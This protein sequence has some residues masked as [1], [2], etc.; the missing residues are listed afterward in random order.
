MLS[1]GNSAFWQIKFRC[2]KNFYFSIV[3]KLLVFLV[4]F[5]SK[6]N[7]TNTLKGCYLGVSILEAFWGRFEA[8]SSKTEV[9]KP[10]SFK[11]WVRIQIQLPL[12][13]P[14]EK[15]QKKIFGC[16]S[17]QKSKIGYTNKRVCPKYIDRVTYFTHIVF[18]DNI[19]HGWPGT[20]LS[21]LDNYVT[22]S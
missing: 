15:L 7:P 21:C 5:F 19:C 16:K 1:F 4:L 22:E 13:Y 17:K 9:P 8:R 2:L 18:F 20:I 10:P 14:N 6:N 3:L 11:H 12:K